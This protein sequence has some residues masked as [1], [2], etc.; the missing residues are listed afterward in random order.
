MTPAFCYEDRCKMSDSVSPVGGRNKIGQIGTVSRQR[1]REKIG[2]FMCICSV[3]TDGRI[4]GTSGELDDPLMTWR[5]VISPF[6]VS[7]HFHCLFFSL[8]C[9][10]L[11]DNDRHRITLLSELIAQGY[12]LKT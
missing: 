2:K 3:N 12:R 4:G 7:R 9:D 8:A 10:N 11:L 6:L 5:L 1:R